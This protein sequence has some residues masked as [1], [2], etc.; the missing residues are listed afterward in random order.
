MNLCV[1]LRVMVYLTI[2]P[3]AQGAKF[4]PL[5]ARIQVLRLGYNVQNA[6]YSVHIATTEIKYYL[7]QI[8]TPNYKTDNCL[9]F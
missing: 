2:L 7:G 3:V 1:Y 6:K 8:R 4:R 5:K 9:M